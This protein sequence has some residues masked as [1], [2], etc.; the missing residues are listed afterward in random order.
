MHSGL[1][2]QGTDG[3]AVAGQTGH[4]PPRQVYVPPSGMH[5]ALA[6]GVEEALLGPDVQP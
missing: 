1:F 4:D 5:V 2:S 6:S 3:A